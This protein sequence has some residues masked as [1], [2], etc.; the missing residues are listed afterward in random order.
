MLLNKFSHF[1][2]KGIVG[3]DKHVVLFYKRLILFTESVIGT[4]VDFILADKEKTE[5]ASRCFLFYQE[6]GHYPVPEHRHSDYQHAEQAGGGALH[7]LWHAESTHSLKDYIDGP[8]R[9]EYEH[10]FK[11]GKQAYRRPEESERRHGKHDELLAHIFFEHIA[12]LSRQCET[13]QEKHCEIAEE[14]SDESGERGL[15]PV[16]NRYIGFIEYHCTL[17][18]CSKRYHRIVASRSEFI[19]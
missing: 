7:L 14:E 12:R 18:Y 6:F 3:G 17:R 9:Q 13:P 11:H 5:L 16:A 8:E 15:C 19:G 1:W 2:N 10:R 4:L